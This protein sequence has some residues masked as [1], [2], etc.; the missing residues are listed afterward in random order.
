MIKIK[1]KRLPL[2]KSQGPVRREKTE[3]SSIEFIG[4]QMPQHEQNWLNSLIHKASIN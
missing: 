1:F 4:Y 3:G 2:R